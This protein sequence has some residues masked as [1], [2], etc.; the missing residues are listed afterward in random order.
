METRVG[1]DGGAQNDAVGSW[2][3]LRSVQRFCAAVAAGRR[4][5]VDQRT[6]RQ[7]LRGRFALADRE[8]CCF[9]AGVS[10]AFQKIAVIG[11]GAIGTYYGVRLARG[12]ADV[13]LLLRSDLEAVRAR[14]VLVIR[15]PE[16]TLELRPPQV[17]G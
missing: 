8:H 4:Y 7:D 16:P 11:A 13:R 3:S 5:Y 10:V 17:Y 6:T 9:G 2:T 12:G 14:G 15:E 1:F